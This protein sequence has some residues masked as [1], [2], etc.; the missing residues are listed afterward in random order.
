M[1]LGVV[2]GFPIM[3]ALSTY[4]YM[5]ISGAVQS[6]PRTITVEG[7]GEVLAVSD[8]VEINIQLEVEGESRKTLLD[9]LELATDEVVEALRAF[10]IADS[11]I[12]VEA[13]NDYEGYIWDP[14]C[15]AEGITEDE[16]YY[17]SYYDLDVD[18]EVYGVSVYRSIHVTVEE[19]DRAGELVDSVR[20]VETARVTVNAYPDYAVSN[21]EELRE[22]ALGLAIEDAKNNA[23]Q[24]AEQLGVRLGKL[25]RYIDDDWDYYEDDYYYDEFDYYYERSAIGSSE[26]EWNIRTSVSLTYEI[27]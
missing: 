21:E 15:T 24:R 22:Q 27:K 12:R 23:S 18:C 16:Y 2:V 10:G 20:A 3:V 13:V 7:R 6:E 1:M 5:Q 14:E 17:E 19:L 8:T 25:V 9:E 11:S 26:R 4:A